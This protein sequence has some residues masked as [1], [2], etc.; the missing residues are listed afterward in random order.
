M[1]AD[2]EIYVSPAPDNRIGLRYHAELHFSSGA[3]MGLRL[4]GIRVWDRV[5]G[6]DGYRLTLPAETDITDN[7]ERRSRPTL[8]PIASPDSAI[9]YACAT[10]A[11][12][13]AVLR[14][15]KLYELSRR[16]RAQSLTA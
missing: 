13:N 7:G 2:Y 1:I 12:R 9:A 16:D 15:V 5:P 11:L 3:L 10:D 14:A 6:A 8:R 4:T